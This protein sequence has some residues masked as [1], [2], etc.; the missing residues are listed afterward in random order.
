VSPRHLA[1]PPKVFVYV[2][3]VRSP[4]FSPGLRHPPR[5]EPSTSKPLRFQFRTYCCLA[6]PRRSKS[7]FWSVFLI[8]SSIILPTVTRCFFV[9][10]I[11]TSLQGP[12][13]PSWRASFEPKRA[14]PLLPIPRSSRMSR[15]FLW[16]RGQQ[17]RD[18]QHIKLAGL[19]GLGGLR[20]FD[21]VA[22]KYVIDVA[23]NRDIF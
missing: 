19:P 20:H 15:K 11:S 10:K 13:S 3:V 1:T 18:I 17:D 4:G 21:K 14:A 16:I 9:S 2:R 23:I 5:M 6:A 8:R 22:G 12:R 7:F